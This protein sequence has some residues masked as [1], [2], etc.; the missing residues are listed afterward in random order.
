MDGLAELALALSTD[1]VAD[2][3]AAAEELAEQAHPWA[4]VSLVGP[5]AMYDFVPTD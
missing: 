1:Q 4:R 3:E 2:F 5:M